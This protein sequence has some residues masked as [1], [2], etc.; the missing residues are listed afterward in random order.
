MYIG[1]AQDDAQITRCFSVM[2]ELREHL[3]S[4]E[5]VERIRR[6]QIS[7]YKLAYLEDESEVQSVAG[8]R[9]GEN[10]ALGRFLYVDD[11]VTAS[12]SRSRGYGDALFDWLVEYARSQGCRHLHLDSGVQRF[13]AHAFYLRKRMRI[14]S[15]HFALAL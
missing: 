11:L 10:L 15:H 13:R 3:V 12:K 8:I 5:F 1:F 6:Q 2:A 14:S 9:P 7:G 4:T